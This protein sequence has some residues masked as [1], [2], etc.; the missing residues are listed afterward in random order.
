MVMS[1]MATSKITADKY[2][3]KAPVDG[4]MTPLELFTFDDNVDGDD[5]DD[6]LL[7]GAGFDYIKTLGAFHAPKIVT[8]RIQGVGS[9]AGQPDNN[10]GPTNPYN[11]KFVGA[12]G[13]DFNNMDIFGTDGFPTGSGGNGD[14]IVTKQIQLNGDSST[15]SFVSHADSDAQRYPYFETKNT[16]GA[17][18]RGERFAVRVD[19]TM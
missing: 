2:W 19:E 5:G 6:Q 17:N 18:W 16:S 11:I 12:A 9:G 10:P 13:I 1:N 3:I 8:V 15:F 14:L 7:F 4:V